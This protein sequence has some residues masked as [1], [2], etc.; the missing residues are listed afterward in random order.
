MWIITT[1]ISNVTPNHDN[2]HPT[3]TKAPNDEAQD[4]DMSWVC[5]I[6]I[7]CINWDSKMEPNEELE[8][9]QENMKI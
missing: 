1:I 4:A 7:C 8:V 3:I 9:A 5:F 6:F 2:C